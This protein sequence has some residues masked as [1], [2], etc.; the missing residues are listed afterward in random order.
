MS[1]PTPPRY[2]SSENTY[3]LDPE[4][5]AEMARLNAQDRLV[6]ECMGGLFPEHPDLTRV[7]RVLDIACGPGAWATE[8]AYTNPHTEVVG[9]DISQRMT[10]YAQTQARVQ[11]IDN[12]RFII[13]DATKPLDFP[14]NHFDLVNGRFMV[15]FLS[16]QLWPSAAQELVRVTRPG[17]LVRLTESESPGPMTSYALEKLCRFVGGAAQLTG[18]SF[19]PLHGGSSVCITPMLELFLREAGCRDFQRKAHVLDFSAGTKGNRGVFENYK[20]IM[21]LIQPF[22]LKVGISNQNELD[23]LYEQMLI[24]LQSA[25]FR[26]LWYFFSVWGR[27][28]NET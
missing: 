9:I 7:R 5:A 13:M 12:V 14:D 20:V 19:A 8:L 15:G 4:S 17:G 11:G 23:R 3:V 28:P 18:R 10:H 25:D 26:G 1:T 6:T 21:K 27:K 22:L 16:N 2:P 24:E